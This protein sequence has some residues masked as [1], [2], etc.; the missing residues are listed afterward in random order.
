M[1]IIRKI[2]YELHMIVILVSVPYPK[3]D[4]D[5]LSDPCVSNALTP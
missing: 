4:C 1:G 3:S 5:I 2:T